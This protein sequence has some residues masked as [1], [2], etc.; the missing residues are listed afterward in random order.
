MTSRKPSRSGIGL[1]AL[2][3][4]MFIDLA[5]DLYTGK[6]TWIELCWTLI[7][8]VLLAIPFFVFLRKKRKNR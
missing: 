2:E 8:C 5:I 4:I 1:V 6:V 3:S 7:L